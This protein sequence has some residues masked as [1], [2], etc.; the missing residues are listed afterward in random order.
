MLN[1]LGN[2]SLTFLYQQVQMLDIST[3]I[4]YII[5]FKIHT[6]NVFLCALLFS[7]IFKQILLTTK[8]LV[9][10]DLSTTTTREI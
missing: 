6:G 10:V 1:I 3:F 2:A 9:M 8:C 5:L 4:Y 7:D